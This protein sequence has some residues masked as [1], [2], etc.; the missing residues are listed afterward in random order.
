MK[1]MDIQKHNVKL[2]VAAISIAILVGLQWVKMNVIVPP[3]RK[4][5]FVIA[6]SIGE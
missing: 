6:I 5:L 1:V 4:V 3:Q 2:L